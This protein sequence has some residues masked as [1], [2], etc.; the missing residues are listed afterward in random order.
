VLTENGFITLPSKIRLIR[1][2]LGQT[3]ERYD[4]QLEFC[5][6][7]GEYYEKVV[8]FRLPKNCRC[9]CGKP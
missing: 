2:P 5:P 3:Y 7:D 9:D 6:V 8:D 4:Y 1:T